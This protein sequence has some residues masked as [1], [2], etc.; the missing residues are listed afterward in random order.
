MTNIESY[1]LDEHIYRQ[2]FK[3]I[4]KQNKGAYLID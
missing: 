4:D 2:L 3:L 1:L